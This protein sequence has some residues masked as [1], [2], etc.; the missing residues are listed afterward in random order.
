MANLSPTTPAGI[1]ELPESKYLTDLSCIDN[2]DFFDPGSTIPDLDQIFQDI[3][4]PD[5]A[6]F[7]FSS[8]FPQ[9]SRWHFIFSTEAISAE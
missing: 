6:G 4:P 3:N 8:Y 9:E 1:I 5:M 2:K 7:D